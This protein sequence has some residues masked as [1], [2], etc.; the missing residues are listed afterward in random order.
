MVRV[1]V[2]VS[3]EALSALRRHFRV[4]HQAAAKGRSSV[5]SETP[6]GARSMPAWESVASVMV[7]AQQGP[8]DPRA[9]HECRY[10]PIISEP[11][12]S[13]ISSMGSYVFVAKRLFAPGESV[14]EQL[15]SV[16]ASRPAGYGRGSCDLGLLLASRFGCLMGAGVVRRWAALGRASWHRYDVIRIGRQRGWS[17]SSTDR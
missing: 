16:S 7:V 15:S 3:V 10:Q 9:S 11:K 5:F 2:T 1:A 4:S 6:D 8:H 13:P 12:R 17:G 14:W